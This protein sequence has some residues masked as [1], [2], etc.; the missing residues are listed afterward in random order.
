MFQKRLLLL[1][2]TRLLFMSQDVLIS[3]KIYT[4]KLF[5]GRINTTLVNCLFL[6][7]LMEIWVTVLVE[8]FEGGSGLAAMFEPDEGGR[9]WLRG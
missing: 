5:W 8:D 7:G 3:M 2:M 1:R 4:I 9:V 6:T